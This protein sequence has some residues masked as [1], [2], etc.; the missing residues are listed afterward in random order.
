MKN[1]K[2][3]RKIDGEVKI[4][5]AKWLKSNLYVANCSIFGSNTGNLATLTIEVQA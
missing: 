3:N 1:S 4:S 5:T 2:K